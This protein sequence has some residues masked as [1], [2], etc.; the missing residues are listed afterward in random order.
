MRKHFNDAIKL[1]ITPK[2][3]KYV[4]RKKRNPVR[5]YFWETDGDEERYCCGYGFEYR[6]DDIE[7]DS[8]DDLN[9]KL[10]QMADEEEAMA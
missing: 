10:E 8:L 7:L 2:A 3:L 6:G 9:K 5:L 4:N 1:M